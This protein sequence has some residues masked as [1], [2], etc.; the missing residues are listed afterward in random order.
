MNQL[1]AIT[2]TLKKLL[3]ARGITYQ[4]LGRKL[5]LSE[6]SVKRL[7]SK[8]SFTVKRLEDI[9]QALDVD[10]Y[11]LARLCRNQADAV[12]VLYLD[13]ETGLAEE[14]KLLML[15]HL[16]L[17]DWSAEDICR[18]YELSRAE[19]V[20]LLNR[21]ERLNLIETRHGTEV[22]LLTSRRI[23]WRR[24]GPVRNRFEA[25]VRN[26]Y[27]D[28]RF[29]NEDEILR[30]EAREISRASLAVMQRKIER[31]AA[32]FLELAELDLNLPPTE[33]I[34]VGLVLAIRPWVFSVLSLLKRKP[35]P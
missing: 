15:F 24:G 29:A 17:S 13:Q 23:A 6:A 30:F 9:C 28:S 35:S 33:K 2:G 19:A 32:E 31:L 16:L 20:K 34:S 7:F 26:E 12:Q 18:E 5:R 21:L 25:Q 8:G 14:P 1:G 10:F 3:K 4:E 27:F 22:R 11:E